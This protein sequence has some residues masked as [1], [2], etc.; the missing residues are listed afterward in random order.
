MRRVV[1]TGMGAL[2]PIGNNVE[3]FWN[4]AIN[5]VSGAAPIKSFDAS[6]FK[7]KF[8]CEL[9]NYDPSTHFDRKDQK[10]YDL[11]AQY[12]LVTV[13]EAL[14]N[15]GLNLEQID[16][17][18]IGV[19]WGS[20]E[21]GIQTF[22]QQFAEYNQGDGTPRFNPYF[23]PKMLINMASGI[24]SIE[25]GFRGVNYTPVSAC[26]SSTTAII[27]AFNY[28]RWNKADII[29]SGG[30]EAGVCSSNIGGFSSL[31]ALS[32]RN[33]DY[34]TASRP[35]DV[36]RD[37]FVMGEGA[38][39]LVVEELEHA[40]RRGANI[41]AEIVGGGMVAD[42]YHLTGINPEGEGAA[43]GITLAIKEAGIHP[44]EVDYIN[45]HATSTPNG[46]VSEIKALDKVFNKRSS[47]YVSGTKSM[48]G[49]L[50]GAAGAIE[51]ILSVK[52]IQEQVV[53]PT[54]N[55]QNFEP[56]CIGSY[57]FPT[58]KAEAKINYV[59]SNTFGFA[60]HIASVLF[61]KYDG[62]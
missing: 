32:Q 3:D 35:F 8:A 52:S 50:L 15:S 13:R 24:I 38:G 47:L 27:D 11:Y 55:V 41:L 21:G 22:E 28:I 62:N 18:R 25:Y 51:A 54:I 57:T 58:E 45:L 31:K 1:I 9:K 17:D 12:A 7:T 26:A 16:L 23:I 56:E 4:N 19:I 40:K 43:K 44:D 39:A 53:P 49:H 2:T 61:K 6:N 48:T 33:D 42:A 5:G 36:E 14:E 34:K 60:G 29:V 46:D 37:G 30:S 20:G 10:K 59:L